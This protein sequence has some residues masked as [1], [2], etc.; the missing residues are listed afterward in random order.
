MPYQVNV[1][2]LKILAKSPPEALRVFDEL[3]KSGKV[4]ILIL[5]MD[6]RP[7][8]PKLLRSSIVQCDSQ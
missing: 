7:I 5:D 3:K 4:D 2:P 6:G 1:G 8:D